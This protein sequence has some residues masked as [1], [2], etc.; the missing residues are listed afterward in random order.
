MFDCCL[1]KEGKWFRYRAAAIIIE[2]DC[3]LFARNKRD[4]YYYSIGGGVHLGESAQEAVMRETFEETGIHYE[5]D[6]LAV[7]NEN[8]FSENHG[9]LNGLD[10]HE[11]CFYFL[12]K[13]RGTQKLNSNSTS[14]GVKEEM[15]WLSISILD[16]Y[17]AF[18]T[19]MKDFLIKTHKGIEHIVT[20]ENK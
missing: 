9:S 13:P 18:P 2:N 15:C 17:K 10:C 7:I 19:F 3:V 6:H 11:I 4:D 12:M 8:F 1:T 14:S 16:K 20:Y 5:V